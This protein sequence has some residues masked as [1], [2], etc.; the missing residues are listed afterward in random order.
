MNKVLVIASLVAS[1]AAQAEFLDGNKL[2]S[3]MNGE[4][5]DR[6]VALGYIM[7]VADTQHGVSQCAPAN[8]TSGQMFDMV[9]Q[10]LERTPATRNYSADIHVVYV[11]KNTWPCAEKKPGS[12]GRNNA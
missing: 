9:K 1:T 2:L 3:K 7:G 10:H 12:N 8:A 4:H 5:T 6:M 11:L